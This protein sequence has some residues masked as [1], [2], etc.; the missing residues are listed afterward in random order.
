MTNRGGEAARRIL[1]SL[2]GDNKNKPS[3]SAELN[4]EG[5]LEQNGDEFTAL[6]SGT[7]AIEDESAAMSGQVSVTPVW[8]AARHWVKVRDLPDNAPSPEKRYA[9]HYQ[10]VLECAA[11]D[12]GIAED[13]RETISV[14]IDVFAY[15]TEELS[16]SPASTKS[17]KNAPGNAGMRRYYDLRGRQIEISRQGTFRSGHLPK[18]V[19][20][21][22]FERGRG[23]Q[24]RKLITR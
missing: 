2:A 6:A 11:G 9:L 23:L 16:E 5:A 7:L 21:A 14:T 22:E 17:V 20:I 10:Y 18:G 3:L 8:T 4:I 1:G 19:Y 12:L 13:G 15:P 24:R